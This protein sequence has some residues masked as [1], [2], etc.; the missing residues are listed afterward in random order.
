MTAPTD[1]PNATLVARCGDCQGE[2]WAW[3]GHPA[4]ITH[5][6]GCPTAI[7]NRAAT[8]GEDHGRNVAE[9]WVQENL[10]R[11][12]NA[13]DTAMA[14]LKGLEDGDPEV[15]DSLPQPDLSGEWADSPTPETVAEWCGIIYDHVEHVDLIQ[16][17]CN[18]YDRG[19]LDAA[20]DVITAACQAELDRDEDDR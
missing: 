6:P 7:Y 3:P 8:L 4:V 1:H 9:W 18:S 5:A 16:E 19:F 2:G 17:I 13:R 10:T 12:R 11:G 14:V 15:I 20:A